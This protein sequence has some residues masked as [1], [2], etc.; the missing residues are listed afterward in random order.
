MI[1]TSNRLIPLPSLTKH[2]FKQIN[3]RN[4]NKNN[5]RK[6]SNNK[7]LQFGLM[8]FNNPAMDRLSFFFKYLVPVNLFYFLADIDELGVKFVQITFLGELGQ[9][10]HIL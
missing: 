7:N 10:C 4:S 2:S 3:L 8:F 5:G 6:L 9:V 1:K